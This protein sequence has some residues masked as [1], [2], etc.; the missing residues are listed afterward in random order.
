MEHIN[1]SIRLQLRRIIGRKVASYYLR[2]GPSVIVGAATDGI[3]IGYLLCRRLIALL[4][5]MTINKESR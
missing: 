4:P 1:A 3:V 5:I 2:C